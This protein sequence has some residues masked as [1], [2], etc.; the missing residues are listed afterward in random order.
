M[1]E[2]ENWKWQYHDWYYS[3]LRNLCY[4]RRQVIVINLPAEKSH[5]RNT[6]RRIDEL[7][8]INKQAWDGNGPGAE[9]V[10]ELEEVED[11][12]PCPRGRTKPTSGSCSMKYSNKNNCQA[13]IWFLNTNITDLE[14]LVTGTWCRGERMCSS[15]EV[16]ITSDEFRLPELPGTQWPA[17][18][19]ESQ[20]LW[21]TNTPYIVLTMELILL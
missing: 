5:F 13:N 2:D 3:Y 10:V 7:A 8:K 6:T 16:R 11:F 21:H 14:I 18:V 20:L 19:W 17:Y 9:H 1:C 12:A 4:F 15:L